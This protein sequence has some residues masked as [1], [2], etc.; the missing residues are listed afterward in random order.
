MPHALV[1]AKLCAQCPYCRWVVLLD[2]GTMDSIGK[3]C[4]H[5][6]GT[7][8]VNGSIAVKFLEHVPQG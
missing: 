7:E 1:I 8:R 6:S 3:R 5:Y 2:A 4:Q